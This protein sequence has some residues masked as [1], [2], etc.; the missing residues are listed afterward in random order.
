MNLDIL[1][2]FQ[3][4]LLS[5]NLVAKKRIP[6]YA[7]WVSKFLA[8]SNNHEDMAI[9]LRTKEFVNFLN[10]D[11]NAALWQLNQAQ[12][13][14]HL[15]INHFLDKNKAI[16]C[17]N[18]PKKPAIQKDIP[19]IIYETRKAIRTRH[20]SYKTERSYIG[21]IKRFYGY[22]TDTRSKE[23]GSSNVESKD[24]REFLSYL[25]I[26]KRVSSS[27]QNQAFNALL[28]LGR[29]VLHITLQDLNKTVRAK[30]G[31]KLPTVLSQKEIERLFKNI[32]G[33]DELIL[34]LIY[35]AGLRLM[36][37]ARLRVKDIDFD[38]NVLII[39]S[40]KGNKDRASVLPETITDLLQTH[41]KDVKLLHENDIKKGYGEVYL[42]NA[43]SKKYPRAAKEWSW[44]YAFPSSKLSIDPVSGKIRRYHISDKTVQNMMRKAVAKAKIPKHITVH[45][46]RHSFATH[47]LIK[48]VNIRQIQELLGHKNIET[49]MI[50]THVIKDITNTPKSP[51]DDLK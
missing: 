10:K 41:L 28:F 23:K 47:L 42:P 49:T 7:H 32:S 35:G 48:G 31:A 24:I 37:L 11:K 50:Y 16:F 18:A 38:N 27:T 12:E 40:G 17:P 1:P 30:R 15:Y 21:W 13:A 44:Q 5:N 3:E 29:N 33:K 45:T 6:F 36:E 34:K 25:A 8:F 43:L 22:L 2:E 20:Y 46:L 51:L 9:N 4:F 19:R 26:K 14:I 39:R